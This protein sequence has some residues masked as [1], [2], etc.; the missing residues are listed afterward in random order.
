[1]SNTPNAKVLRW[2]AQN[3]LCYYCG[4]LTDP[5]RIGEDNATWDH[6]IPKS[7]NG[8]NT[9]ANKV[10]AC[11]RCN[12]D[13]RNLTGQEY[14]ALQRFRGHDPNEYLRWRYQTGYG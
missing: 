4:C 11:F 9:P 10:I 5:F 13:K 14:E 6:I 3:G 1:M 7:R 8:A 2:H 12:Q